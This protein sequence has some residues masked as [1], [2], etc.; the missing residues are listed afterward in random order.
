MKITHLGGY[1]KAFGI[2]L[3]SNLIFAI[4]NGGIKPVNNFLRA[5]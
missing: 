1:Q 3:G 2:H 5:I 4:F